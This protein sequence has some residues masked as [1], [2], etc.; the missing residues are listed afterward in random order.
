[1]A[2]TQD[3]VYSE[4]LEEL[5]NASL[6]S[7]RAWSRQRLF[8]VLFVIGTVIAAVGWVA[9]WVHL[10]EVIPFF[11]YSVLIT[12][13]GHAAQVIGAFGMLLTPDYIEEVDD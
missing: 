13:A 2:Y 8:I 9:E 5:R 7:T 4:S 1:M 11:G 10:A 3:S 12:V 6:A